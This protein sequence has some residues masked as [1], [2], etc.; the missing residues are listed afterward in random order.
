[1]KKIFESDLDSLSLEEEDLLFEKLAKELGLELF[2]LGA[3]KKEVAFLLSLDQMRYFEAIIIK[4]E[5]KTL[6][7]AL[8]NP[9]EKS[10]QETLKMIFSNFSIVFGLI[11]NRDFKAA[12]SWLER[13]ELLQKL[14]ERIPN[15]IAKDSKEEN[16]SILEF[17]KLILQEAVCKGASDVHFERDFET[18]RI[19]FRIDGVLVEYLSL[20]SWLLNPLSSCIKLLSH[21]NITETRIP[22][23]GRFSL[24]IELRNQIIKDFD[25]RVST[26]P[27]IEGESIV[28]RIL[29]KQKTLMPLETLGFSSDELEKI[30]NLFNLP[31]GLVFITGPTGSGK[32]TTMYGILNILKERNLKIITLEDPVEYRL[33]HIS[34]VTIGAKINFASILRNVL[35][36][37]PDVIILGE[38]RDKETLQIA[39]QAA[40]TGHLV[41]ATLHTNDS[42]D[43]IVRL[44]D[45]GLESY[46][47]SQALSGIIAQRLLRKLC[48]HCR[49][50]QDGV[51]ISKG[52][53]MCNYT[54][55]SGRE[56]VAEIL[57][58][59]KD[60]E[61]F[62]AQKITKT[63][64]LEKILAN[65]ESF[66]LEKRALNKAKNGITDLKE[67]YKVIK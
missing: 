59:D 63:E 27:L 8:K 21:L 2:K 14:L 11:K 29:D 9:F 12:I 28:L 45:M 22:Q 34:Q 50:S 32:S 33:K 54:G 6:L 26:L 20:E 13:E 35:R 42:L 5:E 16:S 61:D 60:L 51:F 53:E 18:M 40:F 55:Y 62:I 31:Y 15:E 56:V 3:I 44:L 30:T 19:R 39:I 4:K 49:E 67:V 17:L 47:I 38:V 41:F 7:I 37:D 25:F 24:S 1:M 10:Y 66:T 48:R 43:T 65:D 58:M 57:C 64:I 36:Q 23:D 52:C 46:F